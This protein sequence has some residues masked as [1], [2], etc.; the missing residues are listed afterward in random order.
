MSIRIR[1]QLA[2]IMR[3]EE[4]E[5]AKPEVDPLEAEEWPPLFAELRR[6]LKRI[7]HQLG[8]IAL[9]LTRVEL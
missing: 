2:G 3:P 4:V 7:D 9:D 1:E 6:Q 5:S 8:V